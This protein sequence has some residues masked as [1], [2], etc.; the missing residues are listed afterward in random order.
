M[1]ISERRQRG[2]TICTSLVEDIA[3]VATPG[4]GRWPEAWDVVAGES[5]AFMEALLLWEETGD[6]LLIDPLRLAYDRV[7]NAW[8][9]AARLY[10]LRKVS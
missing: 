4:L 6:A 2:K 9:D 1:T 8:A 7:V 3:K 10:E 5:S